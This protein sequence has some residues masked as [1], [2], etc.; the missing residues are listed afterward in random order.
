ML[1]R[2]PIERQRGGY[3]S[4]LEELQALQDPATPPK[5]VPMLDATLDAVIATVPPESLA[6]L[7][8]ELLRKIF[9]RLPRALQD[10]LHSRLFP[11]S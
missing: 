2:P 6:R 3:P 10:S 11:K 8:D 9:A 4:A 1:G 5:C 7:P